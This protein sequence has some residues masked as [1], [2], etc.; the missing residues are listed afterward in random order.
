MFQIAFPSGE[1]PGVGPVTVIVCI[2]PQWIDHKFEFLSAN[3]I[4]TN[5]FRFGV[6]CH[7]GG[8]VGLFAVHPDFEPGFTA[9]FRAVAGDT[10]QPIQ[11]KI[12]LEDVVTEAFNVVDNFRGCMNP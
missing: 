5:V 6:L 7:N 3:D 2:G 10:P 11:T 12:R 1:E 4:Q 9:G 8:D